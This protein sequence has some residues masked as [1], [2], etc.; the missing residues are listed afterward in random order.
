[1]FVC[2][3]C[4]KN[5]EVTGD[6]DLFLKMGS[7]GSCEDC[8]RTMECYDLPHGSYVRKVKEAIER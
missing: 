7:F 5:Y 1:M 2:E 4:V 3:D 6:L 8:H